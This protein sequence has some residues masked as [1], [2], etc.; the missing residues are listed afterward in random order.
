MRVKICGLRDAEMALY[1]AQCGADALGFVHYPPSP[2]WIEPAATAAIV[3]TLPPLV[4]TVSLAVKV[5]ADEALAIKQTAKTEVIQFYGSPEEYRKLLLADPSAIFAT[6]DEAVARA[7]LANTPQAH[8]L[9]DGAT[10]AHGG[11]GVQAD[12]SAAARL[13]ESSPIL[14]AGGLRPDNVANAIAAVRPWGVDVSSGVESARGVKS[15]ERIAKF[16]AVAK[17]RAM[18]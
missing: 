18:T 11:M 6:A 12:W 10:E 16:I 9:F 3:A 8:L 17:G 4:V 15:R 1:A 14:L 7:V 13:A 2:R 5:S